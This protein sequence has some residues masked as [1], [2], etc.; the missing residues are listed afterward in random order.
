MDAPENKDLYGSLQLINQS[1]NHLS[2]I[3]NNILDFSKLENGE[4]N[5]ENTEFNIYDVVNEAVSINVRNEKRLYPFTC[6]FFDEVITTTYVGDALRLKQIIVNMVNNAIKFTPDEGIVEIRVLSVPLQDDNVKV[7]IDVKDTGIGIKEEDRPKIFKQF[8]QTDASIT[9]KFGGSGLGLSI[10]KR[11]ANLMRGDITFTSNIPQGA[12]F[13]CEVTFKN[14]NNTFKEQDLIPAVA[15]GWK[16]IIQ[17]DNTTSLTCTIEHMKRLGFVNIAGATECEIQVDNT[18][19]YIINMRST[20]VMK[21]FDHWKEVIEKHQ[22]NIIIHTVPYVKSALDFTYKYEVLGPFISKEFIS[23]V[24]SICRDKGLLEASL[25]KTVIS[26][27][28]MLNV[29]DFLWR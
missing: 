13:T 4:Y 11:L 14:S 25:Q 27:K 28:D 21:N 22:E 15:T 16:I 23:A 10:C 19:L 20:C 29:K 12:I 7:R 6:I 2:D 17:D 18:S 1:A 3:I 24:Q 26:E 8:S 9:R 5:L